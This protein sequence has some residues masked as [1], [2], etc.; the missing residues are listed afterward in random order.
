MTPKLLAA[1]RKNA[2]K[3]GAAGALDAV[4]NN[5][6]FTGLAAQ[7]ERQV[8][9]ELSQPNGRRGVVQKAAQ[10]LETVARLYWAAICTAGEAGDFEKMTSYVKVYGWVQSSAIRAML[11]FDAIKD[12]TPQSLDGLLGKGVDNAD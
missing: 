6:P 8:T 3:H 5:K 1:Q 12:D 4:Q 9:E 2:T 7:E 11:A 10:R